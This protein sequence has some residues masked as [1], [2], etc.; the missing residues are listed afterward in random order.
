VHD[1]CGWITAGEDNLYAGYWLEDFFI[2][3]SAVQLRP[4]E[5][6]QLPL[7]VSLE[8]LSAAEG[9]ADLDRRQMKGRLCALIDGWQVHL[10]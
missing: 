7:P 8:D 6:E 1:Y 2:D 3:F 4:D 5:I 10:P 9:V